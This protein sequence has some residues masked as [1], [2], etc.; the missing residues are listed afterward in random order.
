MLE[1]HISYFLMCVCDMFEY[2][3]ACWLELKLHCGQVMYV[4]D[5]V[6]CDLQDNLL[7]YSTVILG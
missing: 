2:M 6:T 4:W 1:I 5:V 7:L 3:I